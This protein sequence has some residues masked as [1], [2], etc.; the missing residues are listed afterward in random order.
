MINSDDHIHENSIEGY[1]H[2]CRLK[3]G[4]SIREM[5]EKKGYN[6]EQLAE[7]MKVSRTTISKIEN[8][9]FNCSM[10]YL[11]KFSWF[12]DFNFSIMDNKVKE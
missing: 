6:Q 2:N 8:G 3:M 5:R 12:L 1:L 7:I 9:K 4:E 10:D 11:S